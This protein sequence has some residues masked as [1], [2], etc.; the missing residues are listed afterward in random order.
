MQELRRIRLLAFAGM[1]A[2]AGACQSPDRPELRGNLYFGAGQYL[3]QLDLRNGNTTVVANIGDVEVQEIS[4]QRDERLLLTVFGPVNRR[5]RHR[6]VLYDL[7][8]RQTLTLANGRY[9]RYLPGTE[10]LVFDDGMKIVVAERGRQDWSRATVASHAFNAAVRIVPVSATR[11]LFTVAGG[12]VTAW[13]NEQKEA[14]ELAGVGRTCDLSRALWI[15]GPDRLLCPQ[16]E[17]DG[18]TRYVL[19]DIDG[20]SVESLPLPASRAM[21]PVAWLPDQRA[22][23]LTEEWS[24]TFSDR[25]KSAV[26]IYHWDT[27]E[28]YRLVA[29]QY[30]GEFAVYRRS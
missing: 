25:V 26:W 18:E 24:S 7:A 22:I 21:H 13:D 29:D 2:F 14:T 9:G 17:G 28:L 23:V 27:H 12:P 5:N 16:R 4:W 15:S 20:V 1:L 11:F 19:V 30:L 10:V 8:T 3:A 6:L